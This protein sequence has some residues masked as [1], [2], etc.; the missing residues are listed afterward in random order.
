MTNREP[1]TLHEAELELNID[2]RRIPLFMAAPHGNEPLPGLILVHEIFGLN[3]HIREVARRFAAQ[4]LRVYAPDLFAAS[5]NLPADRTNLDAMRQVWSEIPDSQLISD[6]K[7]VMNHAVA[8]DPVIP[9]RIGTIGYCMGG[10]IA[11]M[12][13]CETPEI[14]CV[15][16]YYGRIFYPQLTERKPKHPIDYAFGLKGAFLGLFAG[17]DELITSEHINALTDRLQKH[18]KTCQVKVYDKV[19]H[20]FFNDE[21]PNYRPQAAKDAWDLTLKFFGQHLLREKSKI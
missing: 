12:F 7:A 21:R 3:H 6:L 13:A 18:E 15:A 5:P 10:A 8:N 2:T 16:D 14:A 4:N 1:G 11:F 19:P 9:N 17:D 20:A